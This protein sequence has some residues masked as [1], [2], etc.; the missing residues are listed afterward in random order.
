MLTFGGCGADTFDGN[1]GR[2]SKTNRKRVSKALICGGLARESF[3]PGS[4]G[5][6]QLCKG[7]ETLIEAQV[8]HSVVCLSGMLKRVFCKEVSS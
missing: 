4:E 1:V 6:Q 8:V 3:S 7:T 5:V 2:V